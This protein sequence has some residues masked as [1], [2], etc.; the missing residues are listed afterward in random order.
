M[1]RRPHVFTN[2]FLSVC[3]CFS[4]NATF[5][6]LAA[7]KSAPPAVR[8]KAQSSSL[9]NRAA[10]PVVVAED[11]VQPL[12]PLS[13]R[14]IRPV[15]KPFV[16]TGEVVDSWCYASQT[17]GL[18]RGEA[19]KPCA[20]ACIHGG[21]TPGI[22]DDQG[23]LYI[24]AKY[25]AYT[26]CRDLLLPYVAQKVKATGWLTTKGGCNIMKIMKVEPVK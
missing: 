13:Q 7:Q 3:A 2:L 11:Q 9:P 20:L 25:K 15:T 19:H 16:V 23:T 8:D 10:K 18:G 22:V 21:V 14:N 17:M 12:I 1:I 5:H 24:A 26:G 4:L 6:P